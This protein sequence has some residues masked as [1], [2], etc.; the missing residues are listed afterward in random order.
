MEEDDDDSGD[1]ESEFI[2]EDIRH[3]KWQNGEF[4]YKIKWQ[5]WPEKDNTWEPTDSLLPYVDYS[6]SLSAKTLLT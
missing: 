4:Y 5:G 1:E 2:V 6:S 3:H